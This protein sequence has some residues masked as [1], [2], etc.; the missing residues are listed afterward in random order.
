MV[1]ATVEEMKE[2]EVKLKLNN[3]FFE[4]AKY[5]IKPTSFPELNRLSDWILTYNLSIEILGHT[6][7][8]GEDNDNQLLSE[9]RAKA[10]KSYLVAKG[11]PEAK[12]TARGFG[13]KQ[14]VMSNDSV[15]GR[16]QNR[17]VEIK[18]RD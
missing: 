8:V 17:R 2:N 18:I 10:V 1:L 11:C 7:N 12:I 5:D 9:N 14:P 3:L 4:T 6:D 13:E 16:A 15:K